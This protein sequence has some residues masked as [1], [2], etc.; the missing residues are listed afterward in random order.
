MSKIK[1][2]T[3]I[4]GKDILTE[5]P[6]IVEA[7]FETVEFYFNETLGGSDFVELSKHVEEILGDSGV[8]VS[9]IGLYCNPLQYEE[10]RKELEYCIDHAHLFHAGII[11]TFAG[12]LSDKSVDEAMPKYK[13][14]FSEL[15]K[16]A[17][18]NN[19]K[20]G[21]ENAHMYGFWY[22]TTFN[23][24]FCPRAWE[25]MF[26]A[27]NS[28]FLGLEWEPSHQLE[29]LINPIAQLKEWMPKIVH[30]HGKDA[31]VDWD[32]IKKYGA[33]FGS[34][35]CKHRFP[36]LGDSDWKEIF[37][38]LEQGGYTG[39]IAIEG[40]HDPVY[41]GEREMEGQLNALKYLKDCKEG[42]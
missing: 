3:C 20:I 42:R 9:S 6:K 29:Q 24:G 1:I 39:D 21:I 41:F 25:M 18:E 4:K 28:D 14:V 40:F 19:V 10:Q 33:W 36:G 2:G 26:D 11:G 13:E 37:T 38:L 30:I 32:Y 7:G 35:Y 15:A 22:R 16:R 5:L 34:D 23:I 12:A 17:E 8:T 27:V 31:H